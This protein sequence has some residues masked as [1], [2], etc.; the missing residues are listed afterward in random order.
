MQNAL[1]HLILLDFVLLDLVGRLIE[2]GSKTLATWRLR[3]DK[4]AVLK[5][6]NEYENIDKNIILSVKKDGRARGHAVTLVEGQYRLD[7]KKNSF[8]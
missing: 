4:I 1:C 8:S 7:I 6:L 3:G 5:I 2:C